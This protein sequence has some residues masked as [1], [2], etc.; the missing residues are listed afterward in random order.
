MPK[1]K[2]LPN[3]YGHKRK[4][5]GKRRKPWVA[6]T[7][8]R[9]DPEKEKRVC[10]VIGTYETEGEALAALVRYHDEQGDKYRQENPTILTIIERF[11]KT[12]EWTQKADKTQANYR[13]R[14]NN[15]KPLWNEKIKDLTFSDYER[16]FEK[17]QKTIT[18]AEET[19]IF[20]RAVYKFAIHQRYISYNVADQINLNTISLKD[21]R[22]PKKKA[23]PADKIEQAIK[24][25]ESFIR[26][27]LAILFYS[28]MRVGEMLDLTA[29]DVHLPERFIKIRNSKTQ[30]GIR[31]VP[32]HKKLVPIF[33]ELLKGKDP[34]D[35]IC[36]TQRGCP[37]T[38]RYFSKVYNATREKYGMTGSSY[39]T[40]STRHT[41]I[42]RMAE[43]EEDPRFIR[44][45]VGHKEGNV[46]SDVYT[47]ISIEKL[48]EVIDRFYY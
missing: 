35:K 19:V 44:A 22:K 6:E 12:P 47:H 30:A 28:G 3:G 21:G 26:P 45:I 2:R 13:A 14:K 39:T 27:Y 33:A 32:I 7:P 42:S 11:E 24:D 36:R 43:L 37:Y 1:Y 31:T 5:K 25:N 23:W 46:T 9:Y 4:L 20:L 38:E 8:S 34:D 10:H 40:H 18:A 29:S 17:T 48:I 15:L 16:L 41:F